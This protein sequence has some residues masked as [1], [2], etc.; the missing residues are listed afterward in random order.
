MRKLVTGLVVC[1]FA[2]SLA[3]CV[4]RPESAEQ[5]PAA[6]L[7]DPA[8]Q[9]PGQSVQ[10]ELV[11]TPATLDPMPRAQVASQIASNF[12]V[13]VPVI[14][15]TVVRGEAQGIDAW[16]YELTVKA[17]AKAVTAW[18]QVALG[19]RD[20]LVTDVVDRSAE[21]GEGFQLTLVKGGAQKRVVV[22]PTGSGSRVSVVMG[23]GTP[24][25]QTQ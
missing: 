2:L 20:W 16:D 5:Q 25:L 11:G 1:V 18:Y 7:Q 12:P 3:G 6:P 24:V 8:A 17:D 21:G 23:V 4:D 13:E 22:E 19:N 9:A 15:G 14:Q 10:F